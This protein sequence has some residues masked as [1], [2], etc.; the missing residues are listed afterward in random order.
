MQLRKLLLAATILAIRSIGNCQVDPLKDVITV[1]SISS[2]LAEAL[3]EVAWRS[4][5][6]LIAELAQPLPR[7]EIPEGTYVVKDLVQGIIR[8]SPAYRWES[9]G[10]A[11]HVY[12]TKLR[13]A[14]FNFLNLKFER[15]IMPPNVSEFELTFPTLESGRLQGMLGGSA[16]SGFGDP[17]LQEYSL[18]PATLENLTGR[19]I[20][21]RVANES[22]T[23]LTVI[24]FPSENPTKRQMEQDI[25]QNWF[26]QSLRQKNLQPLYVRPPATD[27]P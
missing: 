1:Q 2:N 26:W 18:P 4:H 11:I 15:F 14:R 25:N 5:L 6:P 27:H 9:D 10:R 7:I 3:A 8:Q 24:V 19:E 13:G 12:D 23:F 22:P 21:V 17:S 20:L 16:I